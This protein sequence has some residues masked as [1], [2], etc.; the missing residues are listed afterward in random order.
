LRDPSAMGLRK[1][2]PRVTATLAAMRTEP[3]PT[4]QIRGAR[5]HLRPPTPQD[6]DGFLE[7]AVRSRQ[8]HKPWTYPPMD[9]EEFDRWLAESRRPDAFTFLLC[10][11]DDD[12]LAGVLSVSQIYMGNLRSAYLGYYLFSP[13]DGAGY[14]TEAV[15]MIVPYAFS[16]LGLHR[17]EANI[18]PA[19]LA[20]KRLVRRCGFRYEGLSERYLKIGGRWRDHERWAITAEDLGRLR[21]P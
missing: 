20:S 10:L 2:T 11:N 17:L 7:A 8:L 5:V 6:R 4:G 12:A 15:K 18:Q 3:A 16:T 1:D 19:N 13:H 14:M 9:L 21:K